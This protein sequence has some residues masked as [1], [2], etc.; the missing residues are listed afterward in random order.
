MPNKILCAVVVVAWSFGAA[1][2][3]A[4][5]LQ[6]H[7]NSPPLYVRPPPPPPPPPPPLVRIPNPVIVPVVPDSTG[8]RP[9]VAPGVTYYRRY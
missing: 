4:L 8:P 9:G 5:D 1:S 6:P 3:D 7:L 2:A